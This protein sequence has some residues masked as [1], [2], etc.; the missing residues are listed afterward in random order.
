MTCFLDT[1][2]N[3][4]TDLFHEVCGAFSDDGEGT[5]VQEGRKFVRRGATC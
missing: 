1:C 5:L 4:S 2:I 3:C